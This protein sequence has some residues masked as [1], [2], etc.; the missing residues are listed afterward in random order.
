MNQ[1]GER[2]SDAKSGPT[3]DKQQATTRLVFKFQSTCRAKGIESITML[4]LEKK[5]HW[6]ADWEQGCRAGTQ[7]N[8]RCRETMSRR[9]D[10]D[11]DGEKVNRAHTPMLPRLRF[12][13]YSTLA[14]YGVFRNFCNTQSLDVTVTA[15]G[16]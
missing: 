6:H 2:N 14:Q 8:T 12:P 9:T 4:G 3:A 5:Q 15:A 13:L 7:R 16:V 1:A 11:I 10:I